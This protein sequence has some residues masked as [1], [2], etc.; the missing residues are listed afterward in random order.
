MS[1]DEAYQ[2]CYYE[3]EFYGLC[4]NCKFGD[5]DLGCSKYNNMPLSMTHRKKKC[6]YYIPWNKCN[7]GYWIEPFGDS[8][9][10]YS[11]ALGLIC[12]QDSLDHKKFLLIQITW[13][14]ENPNQTHWYNTKYKQYRTKLR[15]L[16]KF[17]L[18]NLSNLFN[19]LS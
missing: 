13:I 12:E 15:D 4:D 5:R 17:Y 16:Q 10:C 3:E 6:K 11:C 1:Y 7:C 14:L 18:R 2:D 8:H 9:I 19:E